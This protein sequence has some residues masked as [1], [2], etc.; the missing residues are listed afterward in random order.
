[1]ESNGEAGSV[2]V[3]A[4]VYEYIQ[5]QYQCTY[6]GKIYAKN[7]GEID[8]YFVENEIPKKVPSLISTETVNIVSS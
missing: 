2:N 7:V 5:H 8:M 1:M 3:S 6:R 4:S